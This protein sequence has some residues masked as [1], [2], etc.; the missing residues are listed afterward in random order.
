MV[1]AFLTASRALVGV[2]ARSLADAD[3]TLPQFRA[4]VVV[5]GRDRV[6]VS[7]FAEQLGIHPS[8]ATRLCDRLVRKGLIRRTE[9]DT[10]RR[11]TEI[12][13][14]AAGRAVVEQVTARRRTDVAA[15]V[16]RMSPGD[17]RQAIAGLTA[18]ADAAGE[19]PE[20]AHFGWPEP[21]EAPDEPE[22]PAAGSSP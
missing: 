8:T 12:V 5:G 20:A 13:L 21:P 4:L 14:T 6:T 22:E 9:R 15:I 7:R 11:E 17:L 3:V 2:S 10:D 19:V 18:F 1:D 16:A